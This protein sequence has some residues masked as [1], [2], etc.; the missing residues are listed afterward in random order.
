MDTKLEKAQY[1]KYMEGTEDKKMY[2]A[3]Y[4]ACNHIPI[5]TVYEWTLELDLSLRDREF[6]L[7]R[8]EELKND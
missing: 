6:L 8:I 4:S 7:N 5:I 1:F 2:A 3:L